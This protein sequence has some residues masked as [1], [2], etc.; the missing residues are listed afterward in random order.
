MNNG[1]VT[2]LTIVPFTVPVFYSFASTVVLY[3]E[4]SVH[5]YDT[6]TMTWQSVWMEQVGQTIGVTLCDD[7]VVCAQWTWG[8][9]TSP[10]HTTPHHSTPHHKHTTR[11]T[12]HMFAVCV[13]RFTHTIHF[14]F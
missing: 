5:F 9:G 6:V 8:D 3:W 10:H 1:H 2:Y 7:D 13:L 14:Y 4:N 12:K 11:H